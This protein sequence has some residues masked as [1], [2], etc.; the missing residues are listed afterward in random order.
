MYLRTFVTLTKPTSI[1]KQAL[2]LI[3]IQND[4][5][6]GGA[7]PLVGSYPA[8]LKAKCILEEFREKALPVIHIQHLSSRSGSTFCIP[9]TPGAEIHSN[10]KPINGEKVITKNF[11]NSFRETELLDYLQTN[12]ITD[13]VV[14]GMMT[15]MC[16]DATVRAA[17]DYGFNCMLIGEGC[18]TKDLEINGK[19]VC[20]EDVQ[21]AI[22]ASLNYFYATV[23]SEPNN[24]YKKI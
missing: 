23:T 10:V 5:F 21:N 18:A 17:K 4:Y 7:N 11:P 15:H 3:D 8:S 14:C 22:L 19:S 20:A 16:V 13:L 1:M 24:N 9:G 6:E 2:L 12:E